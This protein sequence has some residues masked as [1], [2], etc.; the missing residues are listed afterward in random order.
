M[1]HL[2]V[3]W[4]ERVLIRRG[5]IGAWIKNV[6]TDRLDQM[7]NGVRAMMFDRE[8]MVN[9]YMEEQTPEANS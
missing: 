8:G 7:E 3:V 1:S 2:L 4:V 5:A 9:G 6:D